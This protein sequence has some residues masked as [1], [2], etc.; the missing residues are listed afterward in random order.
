M[1]QDRANEQAGRKSKQKGCELT[2][3]LRIS[4]RAER[5]SL[6]P[7][8]SFFSRFFR[9]PTDFPLLG[10]GPLIA[11]SQCRLPAAPAIAT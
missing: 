2:V 8:N 7:L 9:Y 10:P 3:K 5:Q 11:I 1:K 4:S 6:R